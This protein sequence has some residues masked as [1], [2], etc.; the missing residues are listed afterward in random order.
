MISIGASSKLRKLVP[1]AGRSRA[2]TLVEILIAASILAVF[3]CTSLAALTQL[4]RYAA[5]SRLRTLALAFAQQ[6]ID[7]ILTTPWDVAG[8]VPTILATGT[9][10]ENNLPIDNDNFNNANGLSSPFTASDLQVTATRTTTISSV[11]TR[12]INAVV[13]VTY[14]YRGRSYSVSMNTMRTTDNI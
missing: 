3:A 1:Q 13:T 14:S 9:T 8:A 12:I 10:T 6:K 11:R 5:V 7:I 2:F 4:N